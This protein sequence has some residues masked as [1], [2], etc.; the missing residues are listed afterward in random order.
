MANFIRFDWAVKRLLRQKA[1]FVVLEG[2]LSTLLGESIRIERLLES[3]GNQ[4]E[5]NDKFNRVDMLAENSR[6][7]LLI[8]E[9]Q[10][11][12]ELDYFHRMLYGVSKA[13][14]EYIHLGESFAVVKKIY[15]INIVYFDLGQ[16]EDYVYHGYT[17]F[18]GIHTNDILKLSHHQQKQFRYE[19]VGDLYPEYYLLRVDDFDKKAVTPLDEWILFLKSGEIPETA[20]AAGL[21]EARERLRIDRMNETERKQYKAH[22]EALQYQRSV[23]QTGIIEGRAEGHTEGRI[24]GLA[25]GRAE[26]LVEGRAEG[27]VEGRAE[28]LVEGRAE[29]LVKGREEGRAEAMKRLA[30]KALKRGLPPNDVAELTGLTIEEV[31]RL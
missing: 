10:N 8:I 12:R 1:N 5:E 22:M 18:R 11:T 7:E 2:F 26:G 6:G 3:E 21:P 17:E 25:E 16:G 20:T 23:I 15:S 13:I 30:E 4:E 28:G 14:T 27:L 24:E 19:S 31:L 29:G 9:I